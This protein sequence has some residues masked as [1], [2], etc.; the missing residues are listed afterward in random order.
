M[1]KRIQYLLAAFDR[2]ECDEAGLAARLEFY[3]ERSAVLVRPSRHQTV[4]GM[5]AVGGAP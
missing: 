5:P 1:F 2:G 4:A 3:V